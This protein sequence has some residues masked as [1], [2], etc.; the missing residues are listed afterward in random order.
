MANLPNADTVDSGASFVAY[1]SALR[2]SLDAALGEPIPRWDGE[3]GGWTNWTRA[4]FID[5]MASW[6]CDAGRLPLDREAHEIWGVVL[7]A[8]GI[9]NGGSPELQQYL[10][11]V[12]AWAIEAVSSGRSEPW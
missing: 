2:S 1:V 10:R 7:P 3:R 12:E 11:D 9:W 6:I 8:F 4:S 5:G